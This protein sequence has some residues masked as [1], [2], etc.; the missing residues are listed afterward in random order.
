MSGMLNG[1]DPGLRDV[2]LAPQ[3][4]A[5]ACLHAAID[6]TTL[7]MMVAHPELRAHRPH[8]TAHPNDLSTAAGDILDA[9]RGLHASIVRYCTRLGLERLWTLRPSNVNPP[10]TADD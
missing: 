9:T 3:L 2:A 4:A 10:T 6:A 1:R 7:A 5:L 8:R